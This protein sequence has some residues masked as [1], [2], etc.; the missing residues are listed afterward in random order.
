MRGKGVNILIGGKAGQCLQT[1]GPIFAT[2]V[3]S[4]VRLGETNYYAAEL[5]LR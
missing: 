1:N 5:S 2:G 3:A 4:L